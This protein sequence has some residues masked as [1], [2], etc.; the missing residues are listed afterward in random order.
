MRLLPSLAHLPYPLR[1]WA[2]PAPGLLLV[3]LSPLRAAEVAPTE[4]Q[5]R[6]QISAQVKQR[7]EKAFEYYKKGGYSQAIQEWS[8]ILRLDPEQNTAQTMIRQ[9][10][11]M[12]DQRDKQEQ[13]A[14]F[15]QVRAGQYYRAWVAVQ[16]LLERDPTQSLYR[17]LG[18]RL[19]QVSE[20]APKLPSRGQAWLM[21]SR[22]LEGYLGREEDLHLAYNGLVCATEIDPKDRRF[23]KLLTLV[24]EEAPELG[25]ETVT[26][27]MRLLDYKRQVALNYIYDGKYP[28]AA[29]LLTQVLALEPNDVV[30]LKRLGSAHFAL[31]HFQ[32]ARK[33][34]LRA[35]TLAPNDQKL[36]KFLANLEKRE[37]GLRERRERR[38]RGPS[39][40]TH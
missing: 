27:G 14:V 11:E 3:L 10:R 13:E 17:K 25:R 16:R 39:Q 29:D 5:L 8:E 15:V 9:A 22:G 35:L 20:I 30:A 33:A 40:P 19:Q 7:Y 32:E 12:I 24:L 21:A 31:S 28:L 6:A 2:L 23:S 26:P 34:W 18:K 4:A 37:A 38:R 36:R 1:A